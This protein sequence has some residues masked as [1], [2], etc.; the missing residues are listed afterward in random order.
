M[1]AWE[2]VLSEASK[3]LRGGNEEVSDAWGE[4]R[5]EAVVR[6]E[7]L[8][9]EAKKHAA[10]LLALAASRGIRAAREY[11]MPLVAPRPHR[12][13]AWKWIVAAAVVAMIAAGVASRD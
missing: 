5:G 6:G 2:S 4:L 12:R 10:A 9:E 13:S 11:G 7:Q 3:S 1:S 8:L